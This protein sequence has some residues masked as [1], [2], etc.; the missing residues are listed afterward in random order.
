MSRLKLWSIGFKSEFTISDDEHLLRFLRFASDQC[1]AV[2]FSPASFESPD[3]A[4]SHFVRETGHDPASL[5]RAE[6]VNLLVDAIVDLRLQAR[7]VRSSVDC[8]SALS[9][10]RAHSILSKL[11]AADL[12]LLQTFLSKAQPAFG[13]RDHPELLKALFA[14]F[15]EDVAPA[16]SSSRFALNEFPSGVK[17]V[18]V[19]VDNA[20]K[21]LRLENV[22]RL[23][24]LQTLVNEHLARLQ[25][26]TADPKVDVSLGQVGV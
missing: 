8:A 19:K 16:E 2:P 7:G 17:G 18:S 21:I 26:I 6:L 13:F 11:N 1:F 23:R 10:L 14:L 4:L 15:V 25:G 9:R 20:L 22:A 12:Q 24:F 5:T 3:L